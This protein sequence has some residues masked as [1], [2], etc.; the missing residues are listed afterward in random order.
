MWCGVGV[1]C[2]TWVS[3]GCASAAM[4]PNGRWG[5]CRGVCGILGV[6]VAHPLRL[7]LPDVVRRYCRGRQGR[8]EGWSTLILLV[9]ATGAFPCSL[10]VGVN[11]GQ[12]LYIN[13]TSGWSVSSAVLIPPVV[14]IFPTFSVCFLLSCSC[15]I[16]T[17]YSKLQTALLHMQV[18]PLSC[19]GS[20][21]C[22]FRCT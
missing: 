17:I 2:V 22:Y 9:F 11:G 16:F 5:K 20:S 4:S 6:W 18:S 7:Q 10:K 12:A 15:E 13:R 8:G 3:R 21:V 14:S 1:L 19:L